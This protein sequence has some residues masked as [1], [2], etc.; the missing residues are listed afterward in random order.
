[1]ASRG[2]RE[3]ASGSEKLGI[4]EVTQIIESLIRSAGKSSI[5]MYRFTSQKPAGQAL[6]KIYEKDRD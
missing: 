5:P 6:L 2:G 1:V 3:Q 4:R